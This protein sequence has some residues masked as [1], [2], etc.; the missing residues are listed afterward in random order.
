MDGAAKDKLLAIVDEAI[1]AGWSLSRVCDVI[2]IDR[3]RVWRW[4]ARRAAGA[5]LDDLSP[6]GNPVHGLLEWEVAEIL[7]L[8]EEW[9]PVDRSHRKLAHRGSYLGRV[10]VAPSTVRRVLAAHDVD[11]PTQAPRP[12]KSKKKPWPDW[13]EYRPNQVWG[14]DVTHFPRSRRSPNCFAIIDLVSRKWITTLLSPEETATQTQVIF[15]Q[16]LEAEGLLE[17]IEDHLDTGCLPDPDELPILLAVSDNG[18]PMVADATKAFMALC[19]IA[20]H[21]G[22]PGVPTDQAPIE[23]FWSHVKAD[24]PHLETISDPE[25]LAAELERVRSEYN[26]ARLHAAI[27]YVT[28][29]DEHEGRGNAIRQARQDGL[30]RADQVRRTTRRSMTNNQ[31]PGATS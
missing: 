11:L 14:W 30:V 13:V 20:Q 18:A 12:P 17:A 29:D 10:W 15:L 6:G 22:R 24:W 7:A 28:P 26:G 8:A 4:Q 2:Q 9:G 25:V 16:G 19:S 21:F 3:R 1:A 27:G 23:S 31:P 5:D